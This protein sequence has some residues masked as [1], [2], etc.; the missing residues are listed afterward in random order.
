MCQA[1]CS[2][3]SLWQN[4]TWDSSACFPNF[5]SVYP[6]P[7]DFIGM[8][9]IYSK[10]IDNPSLRANQA[11]CKSVPPSAKQNLKAAFRQYN[12]TGFK[13]E[14]LTPNLTRRA[15]CANWL[16][17]YREELW[18]KDWATLRRERAERQRKEQEEGGWRPPN[19]PV[20]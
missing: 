10:V 7:P 17:Y 3:E 11:L 12:F 18:G 13:L 9:R 20:A 19:N 16:L 15:Q 6:S 8:Q 2:H 1:L 5:R 4:G 14:Q